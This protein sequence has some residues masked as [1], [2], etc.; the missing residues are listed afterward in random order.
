MCGTANSQLQQ[1]WHFELGLEHFLRGGEVQ[2]AGCLIIPLDLIA[3]EFSGSSGVTASGPNFIP[4]S[5]LASG[6]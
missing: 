3:K 2:R 5:S 6:I 1:I 4:L